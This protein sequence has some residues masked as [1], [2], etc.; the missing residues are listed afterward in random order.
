[1]PC[2]KTGHCCQSSCRGKVAYGQVEDDSVEVLV[3][4]VVVVVVDAAAVVV[5]ELIFVL[6]SSLSLLRQFVT[7]FFFNGKERNE[8]LKECSK[9]KNNRKPAANGA[10]YR[11]QH[12][13][14]VSLSRKRHTLD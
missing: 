3:V 4:V 11:E 13:C 5:E 12:E 7:F 6:Q 8:S 1:M 14:A 10:T 9:E 2:A